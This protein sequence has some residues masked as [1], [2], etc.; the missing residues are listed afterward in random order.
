MSSEIKNSKNIFQIKFAIRQRIVNL[1]SVCLIVFAII[2]ISGCNQPVNK[3]DSSPGINTPFEAGIGISDIT[4]PVGYPSYR[5]ESTGIGSPLQ[6]KAIVFKQ[7]DTKGALVICDIIRISRDLS[8]IAREKAAG[9]TGIPF[10]NISIA[11]THIHTGP[12]LDFDAGELEKKIKN[13]STD[14]TGNGYIVS[15]VNGIVKAISEANNNTEKVDLVSGTGSATGISF[16]RRYLMTNGQVIFNPG[17][18]NP[19]IVCPTG[20]V[21]TT[22]HFLMFKNKGKEDFSASL[23][24]FA[25]HTDTYGGTEFHADYPYFVSENMKAIFGNQLISIFGNSTCGNINHIDVTRSPKETQKGI[26]TEK[27]GKVIAEAVKQGLP[28]AQTISPQFKI[29]SKTIFLP[30]Q[31][32]T[33]EEYQW[34]LNKDAEPLYKERTFMTDRRR[35]KILSLHQLRQEEAIQPAVSGEPWH[36]P[37]ELHAFCIGGHTAVITTPGHNFVE[38]G[39]YLKKHS[40]YKNT[41][42]IDFANANIGYTMLRENFAHGDYEAI[43]SRV[44]PGSCEIMFDEVLN[45]LNQAYEGQKQPANN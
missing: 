24:V 16:N 36:L 45:M 35:S 39:L 7:G 4:P 18:L 22:V 33:E 29:M 1:I 38:L 25:D 11:A 17:N 31:N 32:F 30:L 26:I 19:K 28:A 5:G 23:T 27:I 15:L 9:Q 6:A 10:Q 37:V 21:D 43:N 34:A 2:G 42:I 13:N 41:M 3:K 8:R 12:Q 40:P 20:P 44:Q 14:N